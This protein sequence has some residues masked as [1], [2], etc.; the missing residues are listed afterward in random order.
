MKKLNVL[1]ALVVLAAVIA[2][3]ASANAA[4]RDITGF[5]DKSNNGGI[6]P[7]VATADGNTSYVTFQYQDESSS[8][9][10][11]STDFDGSDGWK[12]LWNTGSINRPGVY[13]RAFDNLAPSSPKVV[14]VRIQN[15]M[16]EDIYGYRDPS[17]G[18]VRFS[19]RYVREGQT[20]TWPEDFPPSESCDR[21]SYGYSYTSTAT[22]TKTPF[23]GNLTEIRTNFTD[24]SGNSGSGNI[25]FKAWEKA[26][27]TWNLTLLA[28]SATLD[29]DPGL[30]TYSVNFLNLRRIRTS[31]STTLPLTKCTSASTITA[32]HPSCTRSTATSFTTTATLTTALSTLT[33]TTPER[34]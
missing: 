22:K 15:V 27:S 12:A 13:V 5:N 24:Y 1:L 30:M 11:I 34:R 7:L 3:P 4:V 32:N 9:V 6:V 8:W 18:I 19:A 31:A 23:A 26:G 33:T 17:T 28:Q 25:K 29:I 21:Y 2:L 14:S 10:T 16:A 20:G